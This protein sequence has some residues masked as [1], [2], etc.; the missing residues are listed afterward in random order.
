M[1]RNGQLGELLVYG[2]KGGGRHQKGSEVEIGHLCRWEVTNLKKSS[3][4]GLI[5]VK[6]PTAVWRHNHIRNQFRAYALT[7]LFSEIILKLAPVYEFHPEMGDHNLDHVG[8]FRVLSNALFLIDQSVSPE[9]MENKLEKTF[10]PSKH[11][12]L[13]LAKLMQEL[14]LYPL[15]EKC[16]FSELK[17]ADH[18]E[19]NI[20]LMQEQGG[21]AIEGHQ[22]DDRNFYNHRAIYNFLCKVRTTRYQDFSLEDSLEGDDLKVLL[23]YFFYHTHLKSFDLKSL[24]LVL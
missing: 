7:C 21:F 16:L 19:E 8:H 20:Y 12:A 5:G 14:G 22:S 10:L 24:S 11:L 3:E 9:K 23:D 6:N 1:L 4:S 15:L 17:I 13:F 2:G 18:A